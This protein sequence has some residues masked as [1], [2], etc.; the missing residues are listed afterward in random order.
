MIVKCKGGNYVNTEYIYGIEYSPYEPTND[1]GRRYW[2]RR[3]RYKTQRAMLQALK[4][5]KENEANCVNRIKS[6]MDGGKTYN[7]VHWLFRPIH[8]NYNL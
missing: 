2:F 4:Q 8:I 7:E 1:D 5:L 6:S 3:G